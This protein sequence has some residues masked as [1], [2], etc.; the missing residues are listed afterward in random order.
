[1]DRRGLPGELQ[2]AQCEPDRMAG[3][4]RGTATARRRGN[5]PGIARHGTQCRAHLEFS[6]GAGVPR[7]SERALRLLGL[8]LLRVALIAIAAL[9]AAASIGAERIVASRVWPAQEYTRVTF[10]SARPIRHQFF[11]VKDPE[12]LVIDLEGVELGAELKALPAKVGKTDPYI[13]AVRVALNR[14][15]VVRVVFALKSEIRP[16]L[17]P[18]APVGE[19]QHRLVLDLYPLH[20]DPLL[21][22][23]APPHDP[24][25]EIARSPLAPA[26]SSAE[27]PA[28]ASALPVVKLEPGRSSDA[29]PAAS[30]KIDRLIIIAIDARR[31]GGGW[32]EAWV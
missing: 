12:R 1:M 13:E 25:G 19:Y 8:R 30:A 20:P 18:L 15:D 22:L 31:G 9:A 6:G 17:F 14:P 29:K 7:A 24:I 10:E 23:V 11:F 2:R 4:G 28:P 26:Q 5:R 21:A 16:F 3:K 27:A 32:A